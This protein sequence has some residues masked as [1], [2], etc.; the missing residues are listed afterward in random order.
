MKL[1]VFIAVFVLRV[2]LVNQ[3]LMS[4]IRVKFR[5]VHFTCYNVDG[6]GVLFQLFIFPEI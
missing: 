6:L 5:D 3:T 4:V 2:N 1:F